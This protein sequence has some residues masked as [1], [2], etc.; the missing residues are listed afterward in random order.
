MGESY[1]NHKT[2]YGRNLKPLGEPNSSVDL[3]ENDILKQRRYYGADG[4][5]KKI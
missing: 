2:I 5:H 4:G 1:S 3:Y